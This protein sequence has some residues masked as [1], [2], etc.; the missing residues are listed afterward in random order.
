MNG[1]CIMP[2]VYAR[3]FNLKD[4]LSDSEVAAFWRY[5][6]EEF[7]PACMKANGVRTAKFYSGA[8]GLRAD[9]RI[10]LELDH[11]G[12]YENLL[13][14]PSLHQHVA[15]LYAAIDFKT[16]TQLFAREV[17]PELVRALSP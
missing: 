12:V 10:V 14:D 4:S 6:V 13:H 2:T 8:G 15:K 7:L 16:S 5:A 1:R 17:T 11:A 9:L 3:R